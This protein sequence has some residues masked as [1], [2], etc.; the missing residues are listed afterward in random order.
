M[1]VIVVTLII[2]LDSF[3][4]SQRLCN[5]II[6]VLIC[7]SVTKFDVNDAVWMGSVNSGESG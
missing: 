5:C 1:I 3:A 6:L 7:V 2:F 4:T